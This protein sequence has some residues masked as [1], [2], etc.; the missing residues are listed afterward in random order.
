MDEI[1]VEATRP[2]HVAGYHAA[3]DEVAKER[4][5]LAFLHAPPLEQSTQFVQWLEAG[6]GLHYVA[7]TTENVVVGWCDV[8]RHR[9]EGFA[10]VGQLG[11]GVVGAFRRRGVG[12]QLVQAALDGS[13]AIGLRRVELEVFQSN[14]AAVRL[15]ESFGFQHEGVKRAARILD[16]MTDDVLIMGLVVAP[17]I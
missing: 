7:T 9:H 2:T 13:R 1:R 4:R 10:H 11:M 12:R 8:V 6:A 16:G 3:L 15:Y 14:S 17:A 5:Y